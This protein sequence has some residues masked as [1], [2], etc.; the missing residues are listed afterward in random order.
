[1]LAANGAR[2]WALFIND[3]AVVVYLK[4]GANA[5]ANQGIRLNAAGGSFEISEALG[6]LETGAVN[7]IAASGSDNT[8]LVVEG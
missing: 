3:S 8:V 5:V 7:G 2:R 1:M 6:N 4:V